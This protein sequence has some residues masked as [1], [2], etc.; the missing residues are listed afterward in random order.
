MGRTFAAS[1]VS[2][3]ALASGRRR[4]GFAAR[5][6]DALRLLARG[7]R[8]V[9]L[10][11]G[12]SFSGKTQRTDS[13]PAPGAGPAPALFVWAPSGVVSRAPSDF[14]AGACGRLCLPCSPPW[15]LP[16]FDLPTSETVWTSRR[17][18]AP[19]CLPS[20]VFLRASVSVSCRGVPLALLADTLFPGCPPAWRCHPWKYTACCFCACPLDRACARSVYGVTGPDRRVCPVRALQRCLRTT[21]TYPIRGPSSLLF[22]PY[23]GSA[24]W[25]TPWSPPGFAV[26]SGEPPP[27]TLQT[28]ALR[29]VGCGVC[30]PGVSPSAALV[31]RPYL[32]PACLTALFQ[33]GDGAPL[34]CTCRLRLSEG[35]RRGSSGSRAGLSTMSSSVGFAA[36]LR[37]RPCGPLDTAPLRDV[38][39]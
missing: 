10:L 33:A 4:R 32:P 27:W 26:P 12:V 24:A 23:T 17:S 30:A 35:P 28:P 13:A 5:L 36:S 3:E 22:Q 14:C 39:G 11:C 21:A 1:A 15:D 37:V 18:T 2:L 34:V 19:S 16:W 29:T 31:L 38:A 9:S 8:S 25:P 20:A 6:V 7:C